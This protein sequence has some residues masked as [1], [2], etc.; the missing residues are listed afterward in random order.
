MEQI[1]FTNYERTLV[2]IIVQKYITE[3][4]IRNFVSNDEPIIHLFQMINKKLDK[5]LVQNLTD[6]SV[7][8]FH[9]NLKST[10]YI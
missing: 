8:K 5:L 10:P 3:I 2:P 7:P 1:F 6:K 9:F 4:V